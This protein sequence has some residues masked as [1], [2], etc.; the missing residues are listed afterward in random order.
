[1]V[2]KFRFQSLIGW[3]WAGLKKDGGAGL[4]TVEAIG[5]MAA[6]QGCSTST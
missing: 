1:M 2:Q 4:S 3:N 5:T 6:M